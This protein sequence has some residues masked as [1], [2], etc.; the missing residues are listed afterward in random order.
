MSVQPINH[1][2]AAWL[3]SKENHAALIF[4]SS[5]LEGI[6]LPD[7]EK[8]PFPVISFFHYVLTLLMQDLGKLS[9][10]MQQ[11]EQ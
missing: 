1:K 3:S 7:M 5:C 6:V 4:A 9:G 10:S 2:N 11:P 8:S